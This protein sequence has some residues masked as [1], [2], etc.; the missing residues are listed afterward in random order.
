MHKDEIMKILA[1]TPGEYV[2]RNVIADKMGKNRG[3]IFVTLA[4][5]AKKGLLVREKRAK[6]GPRTRGPQSV[7]F[8]RAP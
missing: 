4:T 7:Y 1:E 2:S 5:M 8:Y 3:S 6:G